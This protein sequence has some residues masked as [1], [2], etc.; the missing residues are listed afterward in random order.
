[1]KV[2]II[3]KGSKTPVVIDAYPSDRFGF[4]AG[5]TMI[6]DEHYLTVKDTFKDYADVVP[7]KEDAL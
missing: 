4:A 1:M 5:T 7:E 6:S 3:S 2:T